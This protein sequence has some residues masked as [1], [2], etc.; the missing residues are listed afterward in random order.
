MTDPL[1]PIS[2]SHFQVDWGGTTARFAEVT[3]LSVELGVSEYRA[4]EE[5]T[6]STHRLPGVFKYSNVTLKRG[7]VVRDNN[8]FD[9]WDKTQQ[10]NFESRDV[11]IK[12]LD[13]QGDEAIRWI[14]KR[15]WPVK[16]EGPNLNARA[17]EIAIES[18]EL[19]HEGIT[20]DPS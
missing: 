4:G 16:V 20:I 2:R 15:A 11:T 13:E 14:L 7:I 1:Y 5:T 17:N 10:G 12:L 18:I 19:C 9:W 8:I 3:G 6:L